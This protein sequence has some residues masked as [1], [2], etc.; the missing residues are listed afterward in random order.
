[1][2]EQNEQDDEISLIDL[3]AVLW[4]RK[5]LIVAITL[6]GMVGVLAYAVGSLMLPPEKSY[7]PNVYTSKASMLIQT[8]SSSSSLAAALSSSGLAGMAGLSASAGNTN[9]ALAEVLATSNTTLDALNS[10]FNFAERN[11]ANKPPKKN[12]K[13]PL[14]SDIRE[15]I[16]KHLSAKLDAKTNL[17]V[18]S[19]TDTDPAFAKE[20]VDEVVRILSE[21]FAVLGGNKALEQKAL[22][23]K[24]LADVD[25]AVKNLEAQVKAFQNKYGVMQVEAIATEQITI[26]A[27]LRSELIMKEMEIANYQ[28]IS[29]INDPV[30]VQLKNERDGILAKIKEIETGVGAGSRVMPSQKELPTIA[31]EYAR[32][33]RD[34]AVQTEV[35]KMLTQQYEM[36]KLNLS[37]QEPV[38]QILEMAEVPDKKS[39]PSRGMMCIVAT[40]AAFFLSILVAF[41]AESIEKIKKDPETVAR[42]RAIS[43]GKESM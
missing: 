43:S 16:K 3:A 20:V 19:Y 1:M 37:G 33:Q 35:F 5:W 6:I 13:P 4:K 23:E 36:V 25:T 42:F 26:L 10:K 31:F 27:R 14:V 30:M 8:S 32:L 40:M 9:G 7:M 22:L 28:K 29:N 11:L 24:K 38:F 18:V 21:R 39:G 34:L 12:A 41:I 17:F 15:G 2:E